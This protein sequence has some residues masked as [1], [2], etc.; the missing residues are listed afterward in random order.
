MLIIILL[1]FFGGQLTYGNIKGYLLSQGFDLVKDGSYYSHLPSGALGVHDEYMFNQFKNEL[2]DLSEPFMST[3]FTIS[4][5]SPYD[6]PGEHK[7]SFNS[8]YDNYVNSVAYTDKYLGNF[9]KVSKMKVGIKTH[10]L[11]FLLIIV[12]VPQ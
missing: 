10:C 8:K 11:S 6:F 9:S 5:H 7:L 12:I 4:S 1:I 2:K 3:L